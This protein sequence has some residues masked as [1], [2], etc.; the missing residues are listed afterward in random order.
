[1]LPL[2]IMVFMEVGEGVVVVSGVPGVSLLLVVVGKC[3]PRNVRIP[4]P[5]INIARNTIV[6]LFGLA[7]IF[8]FKQNIEDV[9]K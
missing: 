2:E 8:I 6:V 3:I 5:R 4:P 7:K 1:M 9:V